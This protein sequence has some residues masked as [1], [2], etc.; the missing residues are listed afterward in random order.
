MA[1]AHSSLRLELEAMVQST[2]PACSTM[3][4]PWKPVALL[5][6][7]ALVR[8]DFLRLDLR[9]GQLLLVLLHGSG[10][11][12]LQLAQF[13]SGRGLRQRQ[14]GEQLRLRLNQVPLDRLAW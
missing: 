13:G 8:F 5:L 6:V 11:V 3:N 7:Q 4:A 9:L 2:T 14:R 10:V 1:S 12:R